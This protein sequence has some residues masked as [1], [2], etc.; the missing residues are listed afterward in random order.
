MIGFN[1]CKRE[2]NCSIERKLMQNI[3]R[4][5][6]KNQ[7]EESSEKDTQQASELLE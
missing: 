2:L 5:D 4:S 1:R 7:A 3:I 6:E